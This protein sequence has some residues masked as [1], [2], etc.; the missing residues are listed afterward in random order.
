MKKLRGEFLV[1]AIIWLIVAGIGTAVIWKAWDSFKDSIAK[2]YV[3]KQIT[4]DQVIVTKAN[5]RATAAEKQA[6]DS[7]LDIESCK[8]GAGK[9]NDAIAV[10]TKAR[11]KAIKDAQDAKAKAV[12]DNAGKATQIAEQQRIARAAAAKGESC[13]QQLDKVTKALQ[14][15]ARSRLPGAK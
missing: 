15:G 4:A 11:D 14:D 6:A 7:Q 9:Q 5:E 10:L 2:P 12:V 13:E 8:A 1:E 3:D